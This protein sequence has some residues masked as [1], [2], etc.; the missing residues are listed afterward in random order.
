[1]QNI[2]VSDI[3]KSFG[4]H[5]V[6]N[7]LSY[8]FQQGEITCIMGPSGGGK[9]TLLHI[10]MGL[11]PYERGEITGVPLLKSAVFQEDR[12][13]ENFSAIS[14]IHFACDK[15]ADEDQIISHFSSIGLRDGFQK[16]VSEFSG[17]MRRRV[18]LVRAVL[19]KSDILF[20]DEPLK[21]LDDQTKDVTLAYLKSNING[22][23]V[24]MVTHD[25]EEVKALNG[26]LFML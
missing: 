3:T 26:N 9:T 20:L 11:L 12:L 5:K 24:I 17:G 14:N 2:I 16:P 13:C 7:Q 19:A 21:G 1:M 10:L 8:V 18:A 6:I 22:R 15:R 4:E 25:Y 23:T